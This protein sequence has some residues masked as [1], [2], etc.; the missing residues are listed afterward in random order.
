[1]QDEWD[2]VART[3]V[4]AGL[5]IHDPFSKEAHGFSARAFPPIAILVCGTSLNLKIKRSNNLFDEHVRAFAYAKQPKANKKG[6][7]FQVS[8]K[9]NW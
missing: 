4:I 1:M 6:K 8:T 3:N 2:G 9:I 5:F 7:R